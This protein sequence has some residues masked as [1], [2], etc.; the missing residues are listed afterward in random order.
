MSRQ[1]VLVKSTPLV[2]NFDDPPPVA[3]RW[4]ALAAGILRDEETGLP[5]ATSATGVASRRGIT[6][7]APGDGSF[8]LVA[9]PWLAC[10]PLLAPS[11]SLT[12]RLDADGYLPFD[13]TVVVP[14]QQRQIAAPAPLA[15]SSV[16]TL[17]TIANLGAGQLLAIG[18]AAIEE[19]GRIRHLGP[20]LQDVTLEG[21]LLQPRSVGDPV[22]ADAWTAVSL[23]DVP[24]RRH[25]VV[26]RGRT[27][28][29]DPATNTSIVVPNAAISLTDFWIS[30]A[31]V[32]A[33]LPGLMTDPNPAARAFVLSVA[34]GL[35]T[36]R[37]IGP[38]QVRRVPM[39]AAVGDDRLLASAV[40]ADVPVFR[41]SNRQGLA[42]G[43]LLRIDVDRPE[44]AETVTVAAVAGL[45]AADQP[46]D[47]TLALPFRRVHPAGARIVLLTPGVAA[48]PVTLRREARPGD[49]AIFVAGLGTL[50]DNADVRLTGGTAP[51]E[52]QRIHRIETT[53]DADGY[54]T[55]PPIH[56]VAAMRFQVTAA[57]LTPLTIDVNPNYSDR[58]HWLDVVF[59]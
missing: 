45:G 35:M 41:I 37:T 52:Y 14:S 18:P 15:G 43:T 8:A 54:F 16:I 44:V 58:E 34:P 3:E 5:A 1:S 40:A 30:L 36:T 33:Q 48:A 17:N 19:R 39:T 42:P 57:A 46:G 11:Y 53:S 28:R 56:R 9:R 55:L 32:R 7:G 47:V 27:V 10:P 2:V 13:V 23:G 12:A 51:D 49:E 24:L 26:F 38:G 22:V 20:G 59:A 25:P 29:R 50:P 6:V 4:A 31:D 21:S